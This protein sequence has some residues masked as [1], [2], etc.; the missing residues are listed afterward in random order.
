[1][2]PT[3]GSAIF[4]DT[5]ILIYASF[6]ESVFHVVARTRL[7]ELESAGAQFWT[8]RQTLREYL[9]ATTRPGAFVP[10]PSPVTI[11]RAVRQF[12]IQFEIADENAGVTAD[13]LDLLE[14][15]GAQGK[16]IH[17]ANIA[18][19]MRRYHIPYLLTHN[20]ADFVRYAPDI[21]VLPLIH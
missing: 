20:T 5:N 15:R 12:E 10:A 13:L 19:T 18:A 3:P 8:S 2:A 7:S 9:A 17:D 16:Q 6:P 11:V 1:M 4:V 21:S 14:L